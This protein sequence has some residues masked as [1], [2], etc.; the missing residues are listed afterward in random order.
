[1]SEFFKVHEHQIKKLIFVEMNYEGQ[2]ER[3]VRQ[4][5]GLMTSA[6]NEKI[7]H[8]RKYTLYPIFLEDLEQLIG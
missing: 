1:L 2:M 8:F 5:C 4:E 7:S 6:W 3:V